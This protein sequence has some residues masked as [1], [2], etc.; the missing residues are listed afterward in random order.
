MNAG[1]WVWVSIGGLIALY[2]GVCARRRARSWAAIAWWELAT[3]LFWPVVFPA[4]LLIRRR[5]PR[6]D[7]AAAAGPRRILVFV[8]RK[9]KLL[10][11]AAE[12][13]R[14]DAL[15]PAIAYTVRGGEPVI[16]TR[17]K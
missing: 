11:W 4:F 1:T 13:E 12:L 17:K 7:R 9:E 2:V 8:G 3:V 14:Q 5:W 16:E 10:A 6:I 15:A